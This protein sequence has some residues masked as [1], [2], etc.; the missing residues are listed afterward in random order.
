MAGSA[1]LW[2]FILLLPL[3]AVLGHDIYGNYFQT[4]EKQMAFLQTLDF[5]P[6]DYHASDLGYLF[7][8][9]AP[10]TFDLLRDMVGRDNWAGWVDPVL[11]MRSYIVALVPPG[12]FAV[13]LL[14]ARIFEVWPCSGGRIKRVQS[15]EMA[16]ISKSFYDKRDKG[17]KFNFKRR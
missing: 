8:T 4:P 6:D 12:L 9:Y 16:A 1:K 13:W 2:C 17:V 11:Q 10:Q 5:N 7:V 14:I 15:A 3:F